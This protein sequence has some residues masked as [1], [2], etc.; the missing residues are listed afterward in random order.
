MSDRRR[1][2]WHALSWTVGCRELSL[3]LSCP[4]RVGSSHHLRLCQLRRSECFLPTEEAWTDSWWKRVLCGAVLAVAVSGMHWTAAAGT[5]YRW[6]GDVNIHGNSKLKTSIIASSLVSRS[7]SITSV[8]HCL[9]CVDFVTVNWILSY[10][11]RGR[12]HQRPQQEICKNQS[13]ASS[14]GLCLF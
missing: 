13:P 14:L 11:S 12:H 1:C 4:K 3:L 10:A 9:S 6:K 2:M 7:T 5:V 8:S